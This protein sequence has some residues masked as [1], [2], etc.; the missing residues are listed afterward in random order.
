MSYKQVVYVAESC[1]VD[2][3]KRKYQAQWANFVTSTI[4]NFSL[5]HSCV[6]I[7]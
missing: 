2:C 1:S 4:S 6:H 5:D 7:S 3:H